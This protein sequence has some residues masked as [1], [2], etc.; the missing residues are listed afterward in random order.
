MSDLLNTFRTFCRVVERRNLT[1]AGIDLD[2]AQATVSRHLQEL[3]QRYGVALLRR[4]TR[5]IHLTSA[6]EQVYDYATAL[7]R[8]ESE[9]AERLGQAGQALSGRITVAGPGGFGHRVL[10]HFLIAHARQ[11]PQLRIRVL[12][13]ER[14]ANLVEE[15][16][17]VAIRIGTPAN[18]SLVA[19][20]LG[21]V[22]ELLVAAPALLRHQQPQA[23][24]DLHQLPHAALSTLGNRVL[25]L[26]QGKQQASLESSAQ[27]E[28]DSALALRDAAL[29]GLG[30]VALHDYLVADDIANG[31]LVALLPGWHLPLWPVNAVFPSRA[32]PQR[33]DHLVNALHA[34][35]HTQGIVQAAGSARTHG[36]L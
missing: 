36:G 8:S 34:H 6:G 5:R 16:I 22:R 20:P 19:K 13:S 23:P 14:H 35:L 25:Q 29:A 21:M 7:L 10:N 3:E 31:R 12:L 17:D 2:L 30:W 11:H 28:V 32:R 24:Q 4:T 9:L 27:F 26:Q 18:S 15:G 33:V 1:Q